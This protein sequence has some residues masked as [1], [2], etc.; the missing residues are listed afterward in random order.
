MVSRPPRGKNLLDLPSIGPDGTDAEVRTKC[1]D[2]VLSQTAA[3]HRRK[4]ADGIVEID[5]LR[6]QDLAPA[7]GRA[8]LAE[9]SLT[10]WFGENWP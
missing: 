5:R 10:P 4:V 8:G 7:E 3:E 2:C 9:R 6:S 1:E